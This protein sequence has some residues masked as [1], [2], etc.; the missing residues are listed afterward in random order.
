MSWREIGKRYMDEARKLDVWRGILHGLAH[1]HLTRIDLD[2][3][4]IERMLELVPT[5]DSA[6]KVCPIPAERFQGLGFYKNETVAKG[7]C[8][9]AYHSEEFVKAVRSCDRKRL[10]KMKL[11]GVDVAG[12]GWKGSDMVLLDCGCEVP[13]IDLHIARYLASVDPE[14]L[15]ELGLKSFDVDLVDKKVRLAQISK[16][17][18]RYDRLWNIAVK[19]AER[20]GKPAGEWHVEVWMRQRFSSEYPELSEEQRLELA[21][22]YVKTLFKK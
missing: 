7:V 10:R 20:E 16:N 13:V 21:R 9:K 8:D 5:V 12:L 22:N 18:A 1:T 6:K 2:R 19:H 4:A 3:K 11:E 15:K 17:P 14:F